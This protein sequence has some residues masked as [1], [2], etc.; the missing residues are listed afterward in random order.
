VH[1]QAWF[2]RQP[3]AF[4]YEGAGQGISRPL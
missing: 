1:N 2:H 3:W 4:L